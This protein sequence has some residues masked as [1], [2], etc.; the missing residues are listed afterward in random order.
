MK[1]PIT[2]HVLDLASGDPAA[3]VAVVLEMADG[4]SWQELGRGK[5]DADGR[6]Q[7][8]LEA[9]HRLRGGTYRLTFASGDYHRAQGREAFHPRIVVEFEIEDTQ[10]HYHVPVLLSPF[11]YSTYRGS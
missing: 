2:T 6:I 3:G 1:A 7:S 10:R 9:S 4:P 11:G 5:T 8:L